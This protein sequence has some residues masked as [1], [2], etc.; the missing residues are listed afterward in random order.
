M[1]AIRKMFANDYETIYKK[2]RDAYYEK[3]NFSVRR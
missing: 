1:N 3:N 2:H